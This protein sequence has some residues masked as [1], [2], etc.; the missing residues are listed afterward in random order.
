MKERL[1][2]LMVADSILPEQFLDTVRRSEPVEPEQALL[3]AIL[4]DAIHNYGKFSFARDRAGE[5]RF[6]EAEH[7]IM[8]SKDQ[9]IF[10]F[11]NVC[12]LLGFDPEYLRRGLREWKART[13]ERRK[14][15]KRSLVVERLVG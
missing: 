12:E 15:R 9:W 14:S 10:S 13:E 2:D 1:S 4:E 5:E 3:L 6:H 7:W 11:E 8:R